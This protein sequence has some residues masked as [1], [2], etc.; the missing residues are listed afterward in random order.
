MQAISVIAY[1]GAAPPIASF[2]SSSPKQPGRVRM[3]NLVHRFARRNIASIKSESD[4]TE[5]RF[6]TWLDVARLMEKMQSNSSQLAQDIQAQADSLSNV[7]RHQCG[8]GLPTLREAARLLIS[9]R[10]VLITGIGASLFASIP[11]EYF[12]CSRGIDANVVEAAELLHYRH[13]GYR[14][15]TVVIVSRSGESIEVARLLRL[16]KDRQTIIGISNEPGSLLARESD[17]SF[18][19]GSL[20]DEMVAIQTY[21]GTLL[22]EY[23][24]GRAIDH[25][26][27]KDQEEIEVLLPSFANLVSVCLGQLREW[28]AFLEIASPI[29]LLARGP[30]YSS[31]LEGALLFNEIAKFPAVGMPVASFRHGPVELVDKS[32]RGLIFAQVGETRHLNLALAQD[33]VR[34]GGQV[35]VIGPA[36]ASA[37]ELQWCDI[38]IVPETLSPIFEIVPVQVAALRMAELRGIVPGSFRYTPQVATDESSFIVR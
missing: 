3:A 10:R 36:Q 20:A 13:E 32:F 18:H 12:L 6:Q 4:A 5:S 31:A 26:M 33:L 11:L 23:L 22:A 34:F 8:E 7:L 1:R 30:S 14:D 2:S 9:S 38:P 16:L 25:R 24:L 28:D 15:A 17:V 29:H 35:R 37:S 27:D 21:T 19:I